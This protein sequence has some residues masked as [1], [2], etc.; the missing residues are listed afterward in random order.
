VTNIIQT[1]EPDE[2]GYDWDKIEEMLTDIA[3]KDWDR[4]ACRCAIPNC[5]SCPYKGVQYGNGN[6]QFNTFG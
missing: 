1:G 3:L 6:V 5:T 4:P 2:P